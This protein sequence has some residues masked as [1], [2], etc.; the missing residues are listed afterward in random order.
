ML[1]RNSIFRHA[2]LI[3][4]VVCILPVVTKSGESRSVVNMNVS[5]KNEVQ[6]AIEKGLRWLEAQQDSKGFWS[7]PIHPALTALVLTAYMGE[8]GHHFNK[9]NNPFIQKGYSYLM[10]CVQP[11]G[12]IYVHSLANYNTAVCM[13]AFQLTHDPFYTSV[14]VK[15]RNFLVGLQSDFD[16]K[17]ETDSPYDGGIGYGDSY[18]HSDMS[19]T[20]FALEALYY[21]EYLRQDT[22][23]AFK[24]LN[25]SAAIQFIQRCQN[26]PGYND[27]PWA[28][29]DSLNKGGFVYFPGNSKAGEMI[30]SSGKKA[31]RSYGS[32]SYAGLL[33]YVYARLKPDDLRVKA[34]FEWLQRNYTLDENPGMGKQGLFYYYLTM[35]K[36]LSIYGV[37]ELT[38]KNGQK[39][40]WRKG[41]A[42]KLLDL[43]DGQG[44][45]VNTSGRWWERDPV[46]VTSYAVITLEILYR[47]L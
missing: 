6:Y 2:V 22:V 23:V 17:G 19:N 14:L 7:Q 27:Q 26:L 29:G 13:M 37:S 21:T 18:S 12:G 11:D 30:L 42:L 45:W 44:F 8:P 34:V 28:S 25:W 24:K 46:L 35:A 38:L 43:Q 3:F 5:L 15:A 16:K 31:L 36:A 41:L 40:N 47:G 33:S 10:K 4:S 39:I 1:K 9:K 32:I 20:L